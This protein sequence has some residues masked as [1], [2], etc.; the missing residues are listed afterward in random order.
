MIRVVDA[1]ALLDAVL[2]SDRQDAALR[3]LAGATLIAP[4]ILDL[5]AASA[6]WRLVRTSAI[7]I[8]E[9]DHAL[10]AVQTAPIRRI[11]PTS[12]LAEAWALRHAIRIADAFYVAAARLV[13]AD[14]LTSDARLAGAPQLGVTVT[15][16][17]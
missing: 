16:L 1:S 4:G 5:E 7:T 2:P 13:D 3:A 9:A 11:A 6:L 10:A 8:A 12:L 17:R 15:L 14:L